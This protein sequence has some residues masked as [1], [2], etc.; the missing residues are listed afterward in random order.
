MKTQLNEVK[1]MQR[2]AGI[3]NE[4]QINEEKVGSI[5]VDMVKKVINKPEVKKLSSDLEDNPDVAKKLA[6]ALSDPK[7]MAIL[8]GESISEDYKGKKLSAKERIMRF[9]KYTGVGAAGGSIL[10]PALVPIAALAT[11][12]AV[13]AAVI[14]GG[15]VGAVLGGGGG[16]AM[17]NAYKDELP[18]GEE[19]QNNDD[20]KDQI[21]QVLAFGK[22]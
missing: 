8:S 5:D 20:L 6:A 9:L 14:A 10:L 15:L 12:P 17:T 11:G 1:R 13:L 4:S 18:I 7:A 19:E 22:K 2:L 21:A 16:A 3:I